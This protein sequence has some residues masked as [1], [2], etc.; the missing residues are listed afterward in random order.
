MPLFLKVIKMYKGKMYEG[1]KYED[2]RKEL[3]ISQEAEKVR[4][5]PDWPDSVHH[6][7]FDY[8]LSKIIESAISHAANNGK[9]Y[10]VPYTIEK[11][12]ARERW[13]KL[14]GDELSAARKQIKK[15]SN[16][17]MDEVLMRYIGRKKPFSLN[18]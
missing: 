1:V 5:G 15:A 14:Q 10:W 13:S 7:G 6:P 18:R 9:Q 12:A 8:A 16:E 4:Q 11:W 3:H 17:E 2:F